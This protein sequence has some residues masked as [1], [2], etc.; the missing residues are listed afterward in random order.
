MSPRRVVRLDSPSASRPRQLPFAKH[1]GPATPL[2]ATLTR[3]S[4]CVDF[5]RLRPFISPLDAT[6]TKIAGEYLAIG[7]ISLRQITFPST[8]IK[9]LFS[10]HTLAHSCALCNSLTPA[11]SV[12]CALFAQNIRGTLPSTL[13]LRPAIFLPPSSRRSK[14]RF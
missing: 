6:L 11:F 9:Q 12:K 8:E 2:D 3:L 10:F 1:N 7:R 14:M 4:V 5:K 13:S